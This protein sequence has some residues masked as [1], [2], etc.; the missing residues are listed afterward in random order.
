MGQPPLESTTR[1]SATPDEVWAAVSD[2]SLIH[3]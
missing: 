1:I 3:I 2:L